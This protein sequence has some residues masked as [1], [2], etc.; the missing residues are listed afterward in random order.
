MRREGSPARPRLEYV[1]ATSWRGEVERALARGLRFRCAYAGGE[2]ERSWSALF[3]D[4][5]EELLLRTFA[6]GDVPAVD[7]VV[8]LVEA[9]DWD[10][11]EAHDL[12]AIEFEGRASTRPLLDHSQPSSAWA[13]PVA[14]AGVNQVAVGPVHAGI[15][16]SGHFRFH[17][18]GER[19]L[20]VDPQLFYKHRGLERAAEG[21]RPA[22]G[23]AIA[24]RACGACAVTNSVAFAQACESM[25]GSVVDEPTRRA[26]TLLIELERL[27][28]HLH[29]I[30][31]ICAGVGFA[32]GNMAFANLKERA[33]T[34][35]RLL[36]GH[37]FLFGSVALG[38]NEI[39]PGA[40]AVEEARARLS[41][42]GADIAAAWRA[43]DFAATVQV[44]L[45]GAGVLSRERAEEL[46]A[47][48]P[49]ARASGVER[50]ARTYA[51]LLHY[52]AF[53]QARIDRPSGDCSARLRVR[54]AE[55][56]T[57]LETLDDLLQGGVEAGSAVQRANADGAA[58]VGAAVVEGPRGETV[59]VVEGDGARLRRFHLRTASY[60]NWPAL[61]A[62]TAGEL[63]PDFPLIN[64][65]F[66]LC[67]ACV[68]R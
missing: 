47:V 57:T 23:I 36:S 49:A 32:A 41:E 33:L 59:C 4:G 24:Q 60:A 38:G 6:S 16:E 21:M 67:Y 65:S 19:I 56:A 27:Y 55:L 9:A 35:N 51:P 5:H 31:A 10:E 68:D 8:D 45:T 28:N 11:R 58:D 66:E 18:V 7:S 42:L 2:G 54:A 26:R 37:R 53:R 39:V 44:R 50:D 29:D 20:H 48:G 14:G 30:A 1:A 22:A 64:K 61:A 46:G 17:V 13:V 40:P 52:P 62:A 3:G 43:L 25:L 15:I 12:G 63:L 34:V